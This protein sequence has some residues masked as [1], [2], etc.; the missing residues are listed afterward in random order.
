MPFPG[1]KT[2]YSRIYEGKFISGAVAG[3]MT[4]SGRVGYAAGSPIFGTPA[5]I[6]AFALGAKL[7]CPDVEVVLRWTGCTYDAFGELTEAGCDMISGR[8]VPTA[9][10]DLSNHGLMK[11]ETNGVM[12]PLLSPVWNWGEFYIKIVQSV[13]SGS[14]DLQVQ[15]SQALNYWWGLDSGVVDIKCSDGIPVS[16]AELVDI[17]KRGVS[18]GA[19]SPFRRRIT[20][21]DGSVIND[22]ERWMSPEEILKIDWLEESVDGSIP[23]FD[24]LLPIAKPIVRLLGIYRDKIPPDKD[25]IQI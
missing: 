4:K 10:Q 18:S 25:E 7:T 15:D 24:E 23:S 22:G 8:D 3:A 17:L 9:R 2:Y 16:M 20:A 21:K 11:V 1:V 19:L 12:T 5:G 14:A 13:F 6:N